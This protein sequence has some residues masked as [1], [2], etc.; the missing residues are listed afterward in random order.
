MQ[1]IKSFGNGPIC[2]FVATP[3]G[4]MGDLS[5]RAQEVLSNVDL[6]ACED[7]RTTS[8][9]LSKFS[10]H[11]PLISYHEHN[12]QMCSK[13]LIE[14]L[15]EGKNIAI[16]SD[17]GY[18]GISDP[19]AILVKHLIENG[20]SLSVIPGGNAF[21][22]ALIGSGLDTDHFY[23]HGFLP[24]KSTLRKKELESIKN[25]PCTIIFYESPH[26]IKDTIKDIFQ[27]F[28]NRKVSIS[29]ELTKIHEEYIRG[30]L[31]ELISIDESTLKGEMVI[32]VE[33]GQA[34]IQEYDDYELTR[35]I[36]Q[37]IK[38]GLSLKDACKKVS[39]ITNIKKNYLYQLAIKK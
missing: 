25:M 8:I 14:L 36:D 33:K 26:R 15:Q 12:E 21:I 35:L 22:P 10:I 38:N 1:R 5:S 16:C 30:D 17:A 20:I 28:G 6:I 9:L 7:T 31:N 4:N 23:F 3:I 2:Y 34:I 24:A 13:K 37:E 11:T 29:R 27:V 18:P 32:V 19:G 39:D